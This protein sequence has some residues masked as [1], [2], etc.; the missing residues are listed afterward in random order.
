MTGV[1]R[2][3]IGAG[4]ADRQRRKEVDV[5]LSRVELKV[6]GLVGQQREIGARHLEAAGRQ[7]DDAGAAYRV[8][9]LRGGTEGA[10]TTRRRAATVAG[11][12]VGS[13]AERVNLILGRACDRGQ[14][15]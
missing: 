5:S 3:P 11:A 2:R 6:S 15:K 7:G 8:R 14:P 4:A 13:V 10:G 1:D 12:D 9:L